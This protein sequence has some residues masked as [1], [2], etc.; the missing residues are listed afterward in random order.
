VDELG[1]LRQA[2]AHARQLGGLRD[3]AP[4]IELP[5]IHRS[6]LGRL[7]GVPGLQSGESPTPALGA[8]LPPTLTRA[9]SA[10]LP[11]ALHSPDVPLMRLDF[12]VLE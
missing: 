2:L 7:L 4:I 12:A 1:G 11:F 9:A 10:L 8:L 6:L 5:R 3:D